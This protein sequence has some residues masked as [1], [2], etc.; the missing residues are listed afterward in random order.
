MLSR[1]G[2]TEVSASGCPAILALTRLAGHNEC[3]AFE[4]DSRASK[5]SG[6]GGGDP[7]R[8]ATTN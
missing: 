4:T 7:C 2:L 3:Y 5:P 1:A 8:E 6:C